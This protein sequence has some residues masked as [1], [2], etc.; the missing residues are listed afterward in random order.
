VT[1]AAGWCGERAPDPGGA[2]WRYDLTTGGRRSAKAHLLEEE[3][4]G[5]SEPG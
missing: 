3:R 4:E 1:M 5:G 2:T